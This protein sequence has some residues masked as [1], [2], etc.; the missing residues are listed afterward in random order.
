MSKDFTPEQ[1]A[2]IEYYMN[3]PPRLTG[4]IIGKF[5]LDDLRAGPPKKTIAS[6]RPRAGNKWEYIE[7]NHESEDKS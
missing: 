7:I 6:I 2:K 1:R 4:A 5:T 3:R